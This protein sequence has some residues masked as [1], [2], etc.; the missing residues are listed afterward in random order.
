[1]ANFYLLSPFLFVGF[2]FGMGGCVFSSGIHLCLLSECVCRPLFIPYL[3]LA[4]SGFWE[5]QTQGGVKV[6][7]GWGQ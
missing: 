7:I 1:M 6:R 3:F 5:Y 4:S 2:S